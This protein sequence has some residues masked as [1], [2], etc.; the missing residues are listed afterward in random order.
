MCPPDYAVAGELS[1]MGC[2][3]RTVFPNSLQA[4][5][6]ELEERGGK[7]KMYIK[8]LFCLNG[9]FCAL[10]EMTEEFCYY[11]PATVLH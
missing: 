5:N 2:K 6:E 11:H 8:E 4:R 1:D 7:E 9:A 10:S 3:D